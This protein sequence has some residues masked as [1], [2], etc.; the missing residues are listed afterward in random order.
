MANTKSN[1]AKS[2]NEEVVNHYGAVRLRVIGSA[3]LKMNL[4]SLD[5]VKQFIL[6][7]LTIISKNFIEPTRLSNFTQQRARLEIRTTEIDE[8]FRIS[9]VII[10][11]K[12]IAKSYP[13][14]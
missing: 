8:T 13:N 4:F 3:S 12:P 9:K 14:G 5:R 10:F 1:F 2:V 7:P 11:V 6:L